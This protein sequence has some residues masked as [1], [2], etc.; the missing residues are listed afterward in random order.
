MSGSTKASPFLAS[1]QDCS[2]DGTAQLPAPCIMGEP[3][4]EHQ[5][6]PGAKKDTGCLKQNA[7]EVM[8]IKWLEAS[9]E[10]NMFL[11]WQ[12][13]ANFPD[14]LSGACSRPWHPGGPCPSC[15]AAE[16]AE[17]L[18]VLQLRTAG[19]VGSAQAFRSHLQTQ[20]LLL[21]THSPCRCFPGKAQT[22]GE[23]SRCC[24]LCFGKGG[25]WLQQT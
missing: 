12:G 18:P 6:C 23:R 8:Q 20:H 1:S 16:R 11:S 19:T 25:A 21:G 17:L 22:A 2:Q 5:G 13:P 14:H 15:N 4:L 7:A 9:W 24:R 10:G 3:H